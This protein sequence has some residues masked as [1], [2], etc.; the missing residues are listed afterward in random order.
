MSLPDA[1]PVSFERRPEKIPDRS[2]IAPQDRAAAPEAFL[3]KR[4]HLAACSSRYVAQHADC[5]AWANGEKKFH[6]PDN[7]V[8]GHCAGKGNE[9]LRIA[10]MGN[11]K[12]GHKEVLDLVSGI[13]PERS[14][15]Q[16]PFAIGLMLAA[17]VGKAQRGAEFGAFLP[18]TC[19][20]L[21]GQILRNVEQCV[22][23]GKKCLGVLGAINAQGAGPPPHLVP[24]L[25]GWQLQSARNRAALAPR[26]PFR[27]YTAPTSVMPAMSAR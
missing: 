11:G 2:G 1:A 22:V 17:G 10:G 15:A 16:V 13:E 21:V 12:V 25:S 8:A 18:M 3:R 24:A 4:V 6:H 20:K 14:A 5:F 27:R 19:N 23:D 7:A 9:L 26:H